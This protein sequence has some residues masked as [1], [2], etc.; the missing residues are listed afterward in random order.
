MCNIRKISHWIRVQL[1]VSYEG[2]HGVCYLEYDGRINVEGAQ[3]RVTLLREYCV[4]WRATGTW[5]L[6]W[7]FKRILVMYFCGFARKKEV[8]K[9]AEPQAHQRIGRM[10]E[11]R[12]VKA[13]MVYILTVSSGVSYGILMLL[14]GCVGKSSFQLRWLVGGVWT[15]SNRQECVPTIK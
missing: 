13:W 1:N 12:V 9:A 15:G 2:K 5:V 3:T 6:K 4:N 14:L 10:W 8:V 11:W 7:K